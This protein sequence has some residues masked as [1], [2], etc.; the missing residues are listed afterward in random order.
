M[1]VIALVLF[2]YFALCSKIVFFIEWTILLQ[3]S[4]EHEDY[5]I[6]RQSTYALF[7]GLC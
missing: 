7:Y 2:K 4:V 5:L 6:E 3:K 1:L